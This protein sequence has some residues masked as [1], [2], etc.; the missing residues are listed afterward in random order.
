M[1]DNKAKAI[2]LG[3]VDSL[4]YFCKCDI[5]LYHNFY[6]SI[7]IDSD[8]ICDYDGI[9][10]LTNTTKYDG[11]IGL[12][13]EY[14][15]DECK[16]A[17]ITFKSPYKQRNLHNVYIQLYA[18]SIY[19]NGL[20]ASIDL[21]SDLLYNL[22]GLTLT[23]SE[24]YPSR[25][26]I[27]CFVGG[28]DFSKISPECFSG[29]YH[30]TFTKENIH[31]ITNN[32]QLETLYLGSRTSKISFKIY[33]KLLELR[34]N[35]DKYSTAVKLAYLSDNGFGI[36]FKTDYIWNAE[37]TLKREYLVEC[38]IYTLDTFFKAFKMLY[39]NCFSNLDFLGFDIKKIERF[40]KHNNLR[41]LDNDPIWQLMVDNKSFNPLS[42]DMA[43]GDMPVERVAPKAK[44]LSEKWAREKLISI[45]NNAN[46]MG[47]DFSDILE[48]VGA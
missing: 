4:Y 15:I 13:Y 11:V 10:F 43:W 44:G 7:E 41:R 27:N 48:R 31:A 28:V 29:S 9:R 45:L 26:D 3:G 39:W 33:D 19:Y 35:I 23:Y 25:I 18:E 22:F 32:R 6:D 24:M 5:E 1:I 17:A 8:F 12:K 38:S 40:R 16:I 2:V 14:S 46:K 30:R 37:F 42:P 47:W 20:K 21:V 34:K 36:N